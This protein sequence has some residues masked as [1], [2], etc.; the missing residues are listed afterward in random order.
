MKNMS[1]KEKELWFMC[2]LSIRTT[3]PKIAEKIA[4]KVVEQISNEEELEF[5]KIF[6][7]I[8]NEV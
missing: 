1:D 2:A 6:L 5:V 3:D 8:K 4:D 7:G